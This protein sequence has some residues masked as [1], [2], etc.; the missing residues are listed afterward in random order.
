MK[1]VE[2]W[3]MYDFQKNRNSPEF[4]LYLEALFKEKNYE[5]LI[6]IIKIS[7]I[8]ISYDYKNSS[9]KQREQVTNFLNQNLR[10]IIPEKIEKFF[11]EISI[12]EK[13]KN[14]VLSK[15]NEN[16]NALPEEKQ[17]YYLASYVND[18]ISQEIKENFNSKANPSDISDMNEVIISSLGMVIKDM[19]IK[20]MPFKISGRANELE[21]NLISNHLAIASELRAINNIIETWMF[22]DL[23]INYLYSERKFF[24]REIGE[25]G[26]NK[27]ITQI[28]FLDLKAAKDGFQYLIPTD[29]L[30]L[31][32]DMTKTG[33][34]NKITEYF[35]TNDFDQEYLKI[36]LKDWIAAYWCLYEIS[37]RTS[38]ANINSATVPIINFSISEWKNILLHAGVSKSHL[39]VLLEKLTFS[40][41]AKDLYDRPLIPFEDGLVCLPNIVLLIDISQSLMSQLGI[42]EDRKNA[43]FNKKGTNFEKH[44]E[45]LTKKQKSEYIPNLKAKKGKDFYEL[46]LIFELDKDLFIIESKTQKQPGN[47]KEFYRNQEELREYIRKFNRNADFFMNNE[48]QKNSIMKKLAIKKI[49]NVY[50]VFVSNVHQP[51]SF[52][53]DVYIIDELNYYNFMNRNAPQIHFINHINKEI[54]SISVDSNLYSGKATATQF[55]SLINNKKFNERLQERI[56]IRNIDFGNQLNLFYTSYY[57]ESGDHKHY[58]N[59]APFT[60]ILKDLHNKYY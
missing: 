60:D 5:K 50:K 46:D 49:N 24:I 41:Q 33:L 54:T 27:L 13:L 32:L 8:Y 29:N 59:S 26:K 45:S 58:D 57:I 31:I 9:K 16:Y 36:P 34:Y 2:K 20:N 22:S 28:P 10:D 17:A 55:L 23:T 4:L 48:M 52:L 7:G 56:G 51:V 6:R 47:H 14:E 30:D 40:K 39:D 53:D 35:Y 38:K 15:V 19:M 18:Y 42:D 1:K 44:I 25:F 12:L 21:K 11:Y 43:S 3:N 37:C